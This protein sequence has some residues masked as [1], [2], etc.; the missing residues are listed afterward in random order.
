[1]TREYSV[2]VCKNLESRFSGVGLHRPMRVARY[3]V[4]QELVYDIREVAGANKGRICAVV[5]KFV[6]GGFAGQVYQV[7]MLEI[8]ADDGP[9]KGIEV[10][11][12][13]ALKIL[14]PPSGFSRLFRNALYWFGFQGPFQLQVTEPR[15]PGC[16]G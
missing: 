3:E 4:G 9:I 16:D 1:M 8:D 7:K 14:I 12:I 10:G 2:E 13:Y 11:G 5:K 6:G 15:L